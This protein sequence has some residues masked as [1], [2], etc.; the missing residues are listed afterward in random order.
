[1]YL[2]VCPIESHR[3]FLTSNCIVMPCSVPVNC[4]AIICLPFMPC[5]LS[6]ESTSSE[7][8]TPVHSLPLIHLPLLL[9]YLLQTI[10]FHTIHIIL[11]YSKPVSLTTSLIHWGKVL[12][13]CC[14]GLRVACNTCVT[15]SSSY[16]FD[17]LGFL[18]RENL[19]LCCFTPCSWGSQRN[20]PTSTQR[21]I[22]HPT[23][24][25]Q[26]LCHLCPPY[27]P[28]SIIA[29]PIKFSSFIYPSN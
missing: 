3:I 25:N 26:N 20:I 23:P 29:I 12:S 4:P 13:L 10:T 22:M 15:F 5:F 16:W 6:K 27:L 19:L 11:C 7:L 18:L 14:V 2:V 9:V 24:L 28:I 8:W 1:M 17:N 21:C